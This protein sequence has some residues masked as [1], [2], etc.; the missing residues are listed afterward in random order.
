MFNVSS[1]IAMCV[2]DS[3]HHIKRF[4]NSYILFWFLSAADVISL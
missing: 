2:L 4:K 1:E 3:N